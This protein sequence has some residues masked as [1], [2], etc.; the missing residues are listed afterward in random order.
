MSGFSYQWRLRTKLGLEYIRK[1]A[2][3]LYSLD[4]LRQAIRA[5]E[6]TRVSFAL[7]LK[8]KYGVHYNPLV[9][10]PLTW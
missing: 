7:L 1:L 2:T 6:I 4:L 3:L 8:I 9:P 5:A 10:A